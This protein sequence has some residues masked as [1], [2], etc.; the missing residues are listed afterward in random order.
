[1]KVA[2]VSTPFVA[3]P[4][5]DYGGTELV[6]SELAE[7]LVKCG[8]DVTL[9]ATGD[10]TTSARLLALYPQAQW[11]PEPLAEINHAAW[12]M[13]V[14]ADDAFD[15][16]HVNSAAAL[17]CTR[18][19]LDGP[20]IV[21]TLHHERDENL[22]AFY[23]Y[24]PNVHYIAISADQ[25]SREI[26]L[27]RLDI[28]HH[29]LDP[30]HYSFVDRPSDYAAFIGRYARVK[31]P[32]TAIDVTAEAGVPLRMAGEVHPADHTF[33]EVV[34]ASR[35][36]Q[37]HV[38]DFGLLGLK[39]KVALLRHARALLAPIEWNEPFGLV[40]IEAMLCGCPV[41]A[42]GAG[43]VPELVEEGVTGYI[44]R[45]AE[46]LVEW[47]RPG[48]MLD[49]F[50]RAACRAR[51]VQRFSSDR[52]VADHVALYERL[53]AARSGADFA[54]LGSGALAGPAVAPLTGESVR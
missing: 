15:V 30:A 23:R 21:Y 35:M 48:S 16:V 20:P 19:L 17:A 9:L 11:P 45:S 42:Y 32:H 33:G 7:G 46:D 31:G 40:L 22:S 41:L 2:L 36:A 29:G 37:A 51:A 38:T 39:E 54:A 8:H 5:R 27:D 6:I 10:S 24:Y 53:R 13:R 1:M 52:M 3:V 49:H 18:F 47:L 12:A 26:P 50:D 34:L 4:P 28:I 14:I 44:A 25:A 43:S